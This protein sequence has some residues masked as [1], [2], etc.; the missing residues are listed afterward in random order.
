M[1]LAQLFEIAEAMGL[2]KKTLYLPKEARKLL[3]YGE[4]RLYAEI[5]SG[6]LRAIRNGRRLLIPASALID[7]INGNPAGQGGAA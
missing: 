1:T 3:S 4:T 6:R 7:F 5:N 2:P